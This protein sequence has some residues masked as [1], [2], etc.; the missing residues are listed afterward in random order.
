MLCPICNAICDT[1]ETRQREENTTYRRYECGN[2][3]RFTT[4]ERVTKLIGNGKS[5]V[6]QL[7]TDPRGRTLS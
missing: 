3:H 4:T 5:F 1:K 7:Q 6:Q 2:Y